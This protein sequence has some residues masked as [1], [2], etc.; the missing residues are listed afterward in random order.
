[1]TGDSAMR[2]AEI[3]VMFDYVFWLRDR[4]L[5]AAAELP[6]EVFT[7]TVTVTSRDLRSTLVHELD[8]ESSWRERLRAASLG[9]TTPETELTP[10]DFPTVDL[11]AAYWRNDEVETRRWLA[12]LSDEQLAADSDVEGRTGYPLWGYVTHVAIHG[13]QE[14]GDAAVL[15]TRAGHYPGTL[16]FLDYLDTRQRQSAQ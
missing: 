12:G 1:M 7:S 14:F 15:V 9:T 10:T 2:A 3:N 4:I 16:G 13:I 5:A 8:V 6:P 11:L